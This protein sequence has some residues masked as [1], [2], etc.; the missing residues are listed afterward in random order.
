MPVIPCC[1]YP[2]SAF[3]IFLVLFALEHPSYP[4]SKH[5][6]KPVSSMILPALLTQTLKEQAL[7][8]WLAMEVLT[9]DSVTSY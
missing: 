5:S 9:T 4:K 1:K 3:V 7:G 8:C 6:S 2:Q